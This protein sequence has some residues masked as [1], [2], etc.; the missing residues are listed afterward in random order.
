[1]VASPI[2]RREVTNPAQ[3]AAR[4]ARVSRYLAEQAE[5]RDALND[6]PDTVRDRLEAWQAHQREWFSPTV[7]EI[8][9]EFIAFED[10]LKAAV[11][12]IVEPLRALAEPAEPTKQGE[13]K[14]TEAESESLTWSRGPT[15]GVNCPRCG[16]RLPAD[17]DKPCPDC[18]LVSECVP[19]KGV[20]HQ[21]E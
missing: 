16:A 14:V 15:N 4:N 13:V 10:A 21:P 2:G 9:A 5:A 19:P 7:L 20:L 11:S 1:M 17:Y 6:Y 8:V 18:G 12:F 3:I